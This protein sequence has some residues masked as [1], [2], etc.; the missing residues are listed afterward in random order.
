MPPHHPAY[1]AD[2]QQLR[3][4]C[5]SEGGLTIRRSDRYGLK[6][7]YKLCLACGHV[8]TTNPLSPDAAERFYSTSDY[9][10]MYFSGASV[11]DVLFR[12]V[13]QPNTRSQMLKYVEELG[14]SCGSV[15]EWGC[16]G[17]WNLVPFRD[18]GWTV[19]GFDYDEPYVAL[20]RELL[21]LDLRMIPTPEANIDI[22]SVPDVI[23]LNHVLEHAVDPR[24][25]LQR[26]RSLST[27]STVLIVGIPLL[28]TI[29]TWHWKSFFH[30][31]HIHYFSNSSFQCVAESAGWSIS[32]RRI[33]SGLFALRQ[34]SQQRPA[35]TRRVE[36]ARSA[37][38]L[39]KGFSEPHYRLMLL[40]R[41][42]LS[43]LGLR[44]LA[45]TI[46]KVMQR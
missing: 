22:Q 17:G 7:N 12:K 20:G 14:M 41:R 15:L 29:P 10:T 43:A 42:T 39:I 24:V 38:L 4:V 18:A 44:E 36:V 2:R 35:T 32:H 21:G 23:I 34:E 26:L 40:L 46:K 13:P 1:L 11:R 37:V 45:H 33:E 9:R 5:G 30:V 3:C 27:A 16:S 6:F 31:A 28:E 8:R 19:S 25:L